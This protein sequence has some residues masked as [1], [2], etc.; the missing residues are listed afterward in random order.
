MG[1]LKP[2]R[3]F[4]G[5]FSI[6]LFGWAGPAITGAPAPPP[7]TSGPHPE[8]LV[9]NIGNFQF[10]NGQVI[11]DF[12]VSYVTHGK[13]NK[14]QDNVILA[15]QAFSDDHHGVDYLIGPG[16]AL[17][18]DKYFIVATD[19]LGNAR[20]SHDVTTGPT[21]SGLKMNFPPYTIRDSVN[22]EYKFIKEY[23]GID[24]VRA[25]VG[26]SIGAMKSYQIALSYPN[27]VRGVIPI[28]GSPDVNYQVRAVLRNAM[29]IIAIDSGWFGGNYEENPR[30]G[31]TTALMNFPPWWYSKKWYFANLTNE[32]QY[33]QWEVFWHDIWTRFAPQDA[34]DIYFQLQSW[35]NYNIGDS[36]GFNGDARA[37]LSSIEPKVLLIGIK[38]DLMVRR[39]EVLFAE[40]NIRNV[41][42][43]EIDSALGHL[44]A[45]GFD[46]E[47]NK[48]MNREIAKF[49][50][51]LR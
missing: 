36:P 24:E 49:L 45:C 10:E 8:H 18:T 39:E 9:A 14:K 20:L 3:W 13:L 42:R 29:D 48:I 15:F 40:E 5:I 27:F 43:L 1:K 19:F 47:A 32:D 6:L 25:T 22:V 38:D 33:H 16:K 31:V 4:I 35:A 12:K 44:G 17:D 28:A 2:S 11:K 21:N 50:E 51:G 34:R 26:C 7:K 37:A 41:Q 30:L 46:P 23:L